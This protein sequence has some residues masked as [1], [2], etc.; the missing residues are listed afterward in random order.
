MQ[1]LLTETY[2]TYQFPENGESLALHGVN[3]IYK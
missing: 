1:Y 3:I 2:D